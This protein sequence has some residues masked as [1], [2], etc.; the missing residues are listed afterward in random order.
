MQLFHFLL[1]QTFSNSIRYYVL[2]MLLV[3]TINKSSLTIINKLIKYV[4]FHSKNDSKCK[5]V[6]LLL[7]QTFSNPPKNSS[8][9]EN[10]PFLASVNRAQLEPQQCPIGKSP[11]RPSYKYSF[12]T[13]Y[14]LP[15]NLRGN[16]LL[17]T[18]PTTI[19]AAFE[20]DTEASY[21]GQPFTRCKRLGEKK[22]GG[23]TGGGGR[24]QEEGRG[25]GR[26]KVRE[27]ARARW[28]GA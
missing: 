21:I 20:A 18:Y 19:F 5:L 7:P 25:R 13:S 17:E 23:G 1:L 16:G 22:N 11:S 14:R 12:T 6:H 3:D 26:G 8:S 24:R 15:I 4:F 10:F 2:L 9:S 28:K 27:A